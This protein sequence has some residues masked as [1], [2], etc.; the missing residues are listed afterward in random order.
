MDNRRIA[1]A[2]TTT[3]P[4]TK[5][6]TVKAALSE[7]IQRRTQREILPLFGTIDY[8]PAYDYKRERRKRRGR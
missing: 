1:E 8:D 3:Q 5:R 2:R 6:H 4:R 7:S